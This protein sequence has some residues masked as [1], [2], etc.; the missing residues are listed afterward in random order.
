MEWLEPN[1]LPS[2]CQGCTEDDCYNCD[3]A[4]ARWQLSRIDELQVRKKIMVRSINRMQHKLE[5]ID[6]ELNE[7]LEDNNS[8]LKSSHRVNTVNEN[9]LIAN[10]VPCALIK[11]DSEGITKE[12]EYFN[13]ENIQ[14]QDWQIERIARTLFDDIRAFYLSEEGKAIA[15]QLE[16]DE[17]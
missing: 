1:P 2:E 4:E 17:L 7:L 11:F 14:I 10:G 5:L 3:Y 9:M 13:M 6:K 12:S 16:S 8:A 15:A